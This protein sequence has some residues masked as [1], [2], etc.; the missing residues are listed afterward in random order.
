[1]WKSR[2]DRETNY[3]NRELSNSPALGL[4]GKKDQDSEESFAHPRVMRIGKQKRVV[5]EPEPLRL[6]GS[7]EASLREKFLVQQLNKE[8]KLAYEKEVDFIRLLNSETLHRESIEGELV[9]LSKK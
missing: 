9:G 5:L 6:P 4:D 8:R 7:D 2:V 3:L 1:M